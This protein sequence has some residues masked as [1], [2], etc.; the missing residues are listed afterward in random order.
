MR[1]ALVLLAIVL[2]LVDGCPLPDGAR[3][4]YVPDSVKA[5]LEPVRALR[6]LVLTP[7]LPLRDDLHLLQRWSLFR[8]AGRRQHR[9]LIEARAPGDPTWT[10]I[11]RAPDDGPAELA[12]VLGYRRLRGSWDPRASGTRGAYPSFVIWVGERILA[13]NPRFDAVRVQMEAIEIG[14]DGGYTVTGKKQHL[15]VHRRGAV[16]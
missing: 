5:A 4:A 15:A 14:E 6:R 7:V 2:G 9:M 12:R 13:A 1:A 10:V 11:F 8:S 3:A 16:P